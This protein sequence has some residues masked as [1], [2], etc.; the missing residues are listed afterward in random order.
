MA[1]RLNPLLILG[2]LPVLCGGWS[3]A[4][5]AQL[6]DPTQP[7]IQPAG[8]ATPATPAMSGLQTV[9]LRNNGKPAALI[10]GEVV[11]LGGKVGE[12]RLV[13]V[14]ED[15]V[16]LRGPGGDETLRLIPAAEK[17]IEKVDAGAT[18]KKAGRTG[19]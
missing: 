12:A 13:K 8:A 9:I 1:G 18:A 11:E 15:S 14:N 7:A 10:N 4:A 16:L 6:A 2:A 19:R 5:S 3:G 17:K